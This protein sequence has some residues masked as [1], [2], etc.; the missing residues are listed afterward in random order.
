MIFNGK[1]GKNIGVA[2]VDLFNPLSGAKWPNSWNNPSAID[3]ESFEFIWP[4]CGIG[5][6]IS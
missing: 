3:D 6:L 2:V 1:R 4:F 5:A